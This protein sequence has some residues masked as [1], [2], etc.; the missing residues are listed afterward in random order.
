MAAARAAGE[1][2]CQE[3]A[4]DAQGDALQYD[5]GWEWPSKAQWETGQRH[6]Y[7]WAPRA[8]MA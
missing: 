2:A 5:Y 6:G 7:C 4:R 3:R 8:G 1:D